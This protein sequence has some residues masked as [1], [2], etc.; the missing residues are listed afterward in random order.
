VKCLEC[1]GVCAKNRKTARGN[2]LSLVCNTRVSPQ[3]AFGDKGHPPF[4]APC[5][6][7]VRYSS[8]YIQRFFL[9]FCQRLI[10]DCDL[11]YFF[12]S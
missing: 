11:Y 6:G 10:W 7:H 12:L 1:E 4:Q 2:P 9:D 3:V 5:S 8:E